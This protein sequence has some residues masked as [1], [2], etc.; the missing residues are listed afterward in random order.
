[1]EFT[2]LELNNKNLDKIPNV[3][4]SVCELWI[5]NNQIIK[6]ENLTDNVEILYLCNNNIEKIENLPKHLRCLWLVENNISKIENIPEHVWRFWVWG[7]NITKIENIP[8]SV[9]ELV[10]HSNP[11]CNEIKHLYLKEIKY[12]SNFDDV[13]V[14][15]QFYMITDLANV[16]R[17]YSIYNCFIL[18]N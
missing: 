1:M 3:N 2:T 16:V 5:Q 8:A 11:C 15:L 12:M 9:C 13:M 18:D 14:T 17:E 10:M 6:I 4:E 7:N